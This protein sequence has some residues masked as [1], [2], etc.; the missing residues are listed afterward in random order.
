MGF[1]ALG[2]G[3]GAGAWAQSVAEFE[4]LS[5]AERARFVCK[6]ESVAVTALA[7][8]RALA[9]EV[10]RLAA[11][12]AAGERRL[13]VCEVVSVERRQKCP[14]VAAV[15]IPMCMK[16]VWTDYVRR[17]GKAGDGGGDGA[18]GGGVTVTLVASLARERLEA[19]RELLRLNA[20]WRRTRRASC[21][22]VVKEMAAEEAL[23]YFRQVAA[24]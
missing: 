9:G 16:V 5:A 13:P 12:E 23:G 18:A 4:A 17:C 3:G 24:E 7:A 10:R 20:A 11:L 21:E 22:A 6:N 14:E 19:A 15:A 8:S 1:L 2:A